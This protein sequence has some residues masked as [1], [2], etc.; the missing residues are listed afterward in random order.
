MRKYEEIAATASQRFSEGYVKLVD[1]M[2]A[3][4]QL[5]Q[6][7]N[8]Y[9]MAVNDLNSAIASLEFATSGVPVEWFTTMKMYY[10]VI[11]AGNSALKG[12]IDSNIQSFSVQ[13]HGWA[14]RKLNHHGTDQV[15]GDLISE[16]NNTDL[17]SIL[18]PLVQ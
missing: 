4:A 18:E 14:E 10:P 1:V 13:K 17:E 7:F 3:E 9:M 2:E 8:A 12:S 6:E 15:L 5:S 16:I 11:K